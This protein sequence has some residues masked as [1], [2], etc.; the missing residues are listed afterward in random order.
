L[1]GVKQ[2]NLEKIKNMRKGKRTS[3]GL[4]HWTYTEI[5][6]KLESRCNEQGVLVCKVNPI[7]TSQRC[8]ECGWTRKGN[9]KGKSFKCDKCG[10]VSDSDLNA[11]Q[12]IALPLVGIS[13]QQLLKQINRTGFYWLAEGQAPIVPVVSKHFSMK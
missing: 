12:N 13:N 10:F 5:F 7:Y 2:V 1:T 11:S 4:G 6:G 9:R 8:S 3:R